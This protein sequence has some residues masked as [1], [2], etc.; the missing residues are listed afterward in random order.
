MYGRDAIDET[1][2]LLR[3]TRNCIRISRAYS[4][5]LRESLDITQKVIHETQQLIL[6]SD[7]AIKEF[8]TLGPVGKPSAKASSFRIPPGIFSDS[9]PESSQTEY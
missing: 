1:L 4:R 6:R 5:E 7:E 3:T 8:R 2:G 9:C